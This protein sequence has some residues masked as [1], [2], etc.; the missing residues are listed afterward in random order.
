MN[1]Y[2]QMFIA[3]V[4]LSLSL[5]FTLVTLKLFS[6]NPKGIYIYIYILSS[7]NKGSIYEKSTR[8]YPLRDMSSIIL[9]S[10]HCL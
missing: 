4:C 9:H 7:G 2:G 10:Q 1:F 8:I 5:M 3:L 6:I